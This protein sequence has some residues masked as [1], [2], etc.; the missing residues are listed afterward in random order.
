MEA[1]AGAAEAEPK[2]EGAPNE[3][4]E[5]KTGPCV[6]VEE[7]GAEADDTGAEEPK[8]EGAGKP[9]EETAVGAGKPKE[10]TAVGAAPNVG[11]EESPN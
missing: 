7:L 11:L 5:P 1:N 2:T 6:V 4:A 8:A 10:E 9:K 3:D